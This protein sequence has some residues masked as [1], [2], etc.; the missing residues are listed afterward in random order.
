MRFKDKE[1][2]IREY[3]N[4]IDLGFRFTYFSIDYQIDNECSVSIDTSLTEYYNIDSNYIEF[5][6]I[7]ISREERKAINKL[8]DFLEELGY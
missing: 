4:N 6:T 8:I 5:A 7:A 3:L 1:K 2:E